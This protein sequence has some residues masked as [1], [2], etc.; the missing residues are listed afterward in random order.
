MAEEHNPEYNHFN[1]FQEE[2]CVICKLGFKDEKAITV[3][4]KGI[5]II[6]EYSKKHGWLNL[7]TYL[8]ECISVAPY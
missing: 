3:S 7:G 4:K 5:L 6:I 8:T 2:C 1:Q